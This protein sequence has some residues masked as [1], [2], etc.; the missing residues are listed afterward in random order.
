[1]ATEAT[2]SNLD[3]TAT[4]IQ[5]DT[6]SI[7]TKLTTTNTLLTD[8][9][10]NTDSLATITNTTVG[11][12]IGLDVNVINTS[13]P[14]SISR[15]ANIQNNQSTGTG[16]INVNISP[17]FM[18][19]INAVYLKFQAVPTANDFDITLFDPAN[20][21]YNAT[22]FSVNPGSLGITNVAWVPDGENI[23][24]P[25]QGI[26]ITFTNTATTQYGLTVIY[27]YIV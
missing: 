4:L 23:I 24:L 2:L 21:F 7:D 15:V 1:M 17:G 27:E 9:E 16:N 18:F 8:I 3:A 12:D 10:T 14:I 22:L 26:D 25:S 5:A 19:K 11:S 6:T 20:P 13:L